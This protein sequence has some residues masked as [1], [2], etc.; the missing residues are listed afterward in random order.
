MAP[1]TLWGYRLRPG[2]NNAGSLRITH[3]LQFTSNTSAITSNAFNTSGS[4]NFVLTAN[5]SLLQHTS[6]TSA[7]TSNA[8]NTSASRVIN[9]VAATNNTGGGTASLSSNV[10]FSNANGATFYTSAGG[11]IAMR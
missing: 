4:S 6:A 5:S 3:G 2:S 10:S 11:A 8:L 9:I 1:I 7:I